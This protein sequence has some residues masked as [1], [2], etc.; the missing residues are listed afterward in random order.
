MQDTFNCRVKIS[1]TKVLFFSSDQTEGFGCVFSSSVSNPAA[2]VDFATNT[3]Y[4]YF[5]FLFF[6]TECSLG[7]RL[8]LFK[9]TWM[10]IFVCIVCM[11]FLCSHTL[12]LA[13]ASRGW[14]LRSHLNAFYCLVDGLQKSLVLGVLVAV[15]IGVHVSQSTHIVVKILLCD[16][17]LLWERKWEL[18]IQN[19]LC[20]WMGVWM[21]MFICSLL[22]FKIS[23]NLW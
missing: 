6:F 15:F 21:C 17:F 12:F 4:T 13:Y 18:M 10:P 20:V 7:W 14:C 8:L 1:K 5:S 11:Y 2:F 23:E 22:F 3:L 16:W 9:N 19:N